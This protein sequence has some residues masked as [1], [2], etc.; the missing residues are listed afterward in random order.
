MQEGTGD[1]TGIDA[2]R[3]V[4][5]LLDRVEG[6]LFAVAEYDADEIGLLHL[7]DATREFYPAE[8]V[9]YD[10]FETIHSYVHVD[11]VEK[12]LFTDEL[13]PLAEEVEHVVTAMDF[14]K[15]V[16]IYRGSDGIFLS[17]L[18]EEPVVPLVEIVRESLDDAEGSI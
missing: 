6:T 12:D 9:M 13:F 11:F 18:P 8:D 1:I 15:I 17:V 14:L 5:R 2:D 10:H 7:D 16:R 4:E 3:T